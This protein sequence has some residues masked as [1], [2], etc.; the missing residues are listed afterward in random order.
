MGIQGID[1]ETLLK[2]LLPLIESEQSSVG[3]PRRD[4]RAG[5]TRA[6]SSQ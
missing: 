4:S 5:I 2:I 1:P 6:C 3:Y